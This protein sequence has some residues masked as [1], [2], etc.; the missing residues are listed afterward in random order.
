[1]TS[2]GVRRVREACLHWT[3]A[4]GEKDSVPAGVVGA[5]SRQEIRS[6][7]VAQSLLSAGPFA[8]LARAMLDRRGR[9]VALSNLRVA[10]GDKISAE[11]RAQIVRE[12]YQHFA[13]TVLDSF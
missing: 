12:S 7:L 10:F 3:D 6:A 4:H 2:A 5:Q 11:G 9:R 1:M 13:R 8:R